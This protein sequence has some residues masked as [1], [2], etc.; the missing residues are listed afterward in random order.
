MNLIYNIIY[1]FDVGCSEMLSS[2]SPDVFLYRK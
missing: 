1:I 2:L